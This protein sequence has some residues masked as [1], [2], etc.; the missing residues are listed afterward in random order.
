MARTEKRGRETI[1][2]KTEGG[3]G[4]EIKRGR[5]REKL[6]LGKK[7]ENGVSSNLPWRTAK[8]KRAGGTRFL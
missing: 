1:A 5:E 4:L 7:L 8:H 3:W 2:R 6:G